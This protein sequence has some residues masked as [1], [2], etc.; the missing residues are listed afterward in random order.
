[1]EHAV[2]Y[3]VLA[4]AVA[5]HDGLYEVL[6]HVGI[7]GQ[8]LLGVLGQAVAAVAERGVVVVRAYARVET[9]AA[10][11][12]LRVEALHFSVGVKFVEVAHAQGEVGVGEELHGLGLGQPHEQGVDVFLDGSLLQQSGKL[13]GGL[14][15]P[16]V[17]FRTANDDAAG[18]EV[19]VKGLALA[20]EFRREDY[21]F[22]VHLLAYHL[23][24][25]Y[26]DGALDYHY[27]VGVDAFHQFDDLL[28]MTRVKVVLHRVIVC[29]GGDDNEVSIRISL[30]P[31]Q[32]RSQVEFLFSQVFFDVI[33]LNR[34]LAAVYQV[35]FFGN[36]VYC[37]Y[38]MVLA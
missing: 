6:W 14:V 36:H 9:Y 38:L 37:R 10:D 15:Q 26:G 2:G 35:H 30:C 19:V 20:Q 23:G 32:C 5:L 12:G 8:Q 17:A 18:I 13:V 34:R 21:V 25:T 27:G 1:M 11:D 22:R 4:C 28:H 24:I 31:I 7:V 16:L 29:R 3:E 33:V